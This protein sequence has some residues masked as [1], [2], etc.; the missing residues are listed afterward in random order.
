M[1][2]RPKKDARYQVHE[3]KVGDYQTDPENANKGT[4]RGKRVLEGSYK[5]FGAGRSWLADR[6]G[7]LIAGNQSRQAAIAV[8]VDDVVEVEVLDPNLQ[9]VIRRPD[10]DLDGDVLTARE[11]AFADN[12]TGEVNL[13][14][15]PE[16]I[17]EHEGM[18]RDIELFRDDELDDLLL[19][20][21]IE[22][23]VEAAVRDGVT[24]GDRSKL[25]E[26]Q[27]KK[28]SPVLYVDDLEV[29]E[30]AITMAR[31]LT[32]ERRRAGL[33]VHICQFFL[34]AHTDEELKEMLDADTDA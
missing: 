28:I 21:D 16:Q 6:D 24:H 4:R 1:A 10:L 26:R 15:S 23:G 9:V 12:R 25:H 20:G 5:R 31:S 34:D 13:E 32:G 18:L 3:R 30:N 2:S 14:W 22:E 27:Q 8:G 33:L 7:Q 19:Q 29:F 11:F 17:R